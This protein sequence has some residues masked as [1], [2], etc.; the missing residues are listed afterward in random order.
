MTY[1]DQPYLPLKGSKRK[2]LIPKAL[3]DWKG[4]PSSS[5]V[6]SP[7]AA[8]ESR[9]EQEGEENAYRITSISFIGHSLGGLIQT[10]AIAYIQKHSP[11][12]FELIKPINFIALATP[13][14]GLSNENPLYVRFALDLGL[15]GRTGQDL[16]LSWT[17]PKM[18][19]GWEALIGGRGQ[20]SSREHGN[21]DP[22]AKPLLR[23][24]PSGPARDVLLK[25]QHRTIYS[26]VVNDGI[27]P[28]RTSCLLF[29]DWRGLDR[30]EKA[31]RGNGLVG[32]MAEWG[33]AELTG[34]NSKFPGTI[35]PTDPE[36]L[37]DTRGVGDTAK[38]GGQHSLG[39]HV[40]PED[41]TSS[42][43]YEQ[44][45]SEPQQEPD[46]R[47]QVAR[48][49]SKDRHLS[50]SHSSGALESLWSIFLPREVK[51][52]NR[53]KQAR[54]YKRSQ[55][56]NTVGD[57]TRALPSNRSQSSEHTNDS[58]LYEEE[59]LHAP[60]KTTIFESAGDLL[61]PPLPTTEFIIDPESR[62]RTIFHDR[63]YNPDDI[64]APSPTKQRVMSAGSSHGKGVEIGSASETGSSVGD[65]FEAGLK[66]E[67]KIARAYHRDLP[68]RKVLVR[69]EPDAHNNIIVRRAFT[70]AFGWPVVKHLVDTHFGHSATAELD[71]TQLPSADREQTPSAR[72]TD[73]F[74]GGTEGQTVPLPVLPQHGVLR[75][76]SER[77]LDTPDHHP[78]PSKFSLPHRE[79]VN[80]NIISGT[81]NPEA[82]ASS[83][84]DENLAR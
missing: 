10:Y 41:E 11:Q 81:G 82:P 4:A 16:G 79:S 5:I 84:G 83:D 73:Y 49:K 27:V 26:N 34:A 37:E 18:R 39:R 80:P 63:I 30:V 57:R 64:P 7:T 54:I 17:M 42:P 71:D 53:H 77:S 61:M 66:V 36:S 67:E 58:S 1:P 78:F 40:A 9:E 48:S 3:N 59:R 6:A 8:D 62:P 22:G 47:N 23:I 20:Q 75:R 68:W 74:T 44:F 28:L 55:T 15:V 51:D 38:T 45:L 29:L 65:E 25:F 13:F 56:L 21:S 32:T 70:N 52:H 60:P 12:F 33:W 35:R 69:L 31:N 43:S 19:S 76:G 72:K 50:Q 46:H 14:L 2:F 24:L